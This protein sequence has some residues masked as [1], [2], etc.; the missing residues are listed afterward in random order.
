MHGYQGVKGTAFPIPIGNSSSWDTTMLYSIGRVIATEARAH[1][2]HFILGPNLDLAHEIRW[3]RVEETF[4]EDPYLTS[5]LGVNLVKG[6]QGN[7]LRYNNTVASEPKH[8]GIHG[9]PE[10]GTNAS[11][12]NIS[13]REAR[14]FHLYTFEKAVKEGHAQGVM[15]AYHDIDGIPCVANEW[16]LSKILREEWGFDGIVVSDLGAIRR[17]VNDHHT[18][19]D[20]ED[21]VVKSL[22]AGYAV[23][24]FPL[25]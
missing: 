7:D 2:V 23:L 4:G 5:R 21:A 14:S 3:G 11:S 8:F 25:R 6:M 13:E 16:L 19:V 24:R 1:G 18:A 15:A 12:V 22:K 9:I 20:T 10:S 17:Q